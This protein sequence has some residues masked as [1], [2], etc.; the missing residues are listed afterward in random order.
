MDWI[1]SILTRSSW[2]YLSASRHLPGKFLNWDHDCFVSDPY[3]FIIHEC[4]NHSLIRN[5]Y[6]W[7]SVFKYMKNQYQFI[8]FSSEL[9]F[10]TPL[11]VD[12]SQHDR[13]WFALI[14]TMRQIMACIVQG[15]RTCGTC[16]QSDTRG[17]FFWHA[18]FTVLLFF[19]DQP[20]YIT[21]DICIYIGVELYMI[22]ITTEWYCEWIIFYTNKKQWEVIGCLNRLSRN[23]FKYSVLSVFNIAYNNNNNI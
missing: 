15:C 21:K 7:E 6:S 4:S 20:Y 19:P 22:I 12:F 17:Y 11:I 18:A 14:K 1:H 16:V 8:V 2:F 10:Q 23:A 9:W 13:P 5:L 3:Q